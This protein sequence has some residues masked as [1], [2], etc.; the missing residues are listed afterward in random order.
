[1]LVLGCVM[2][3]CVG[4]WAS[5]EPSISAGTGLVLTPD[6]HT[7]GPA[8][9]SFGFWQ[10]A[11]TSNLFGRRFSQPLGST[12]IYGVNVGVTKHLEAGCSRIET[13]N[14]DDNTIFNAKY[15][16]DL[17]KLLSAPGAPMVAV[18]IWDFTGKINRGAYAVISKRLTLT[19]DETKTVIN[20]HLGFGRNE[21][22]GGAL[23]GPFGGI[24]FKVN[25]QAII[26]TEYDGAHFNALARWKIGHR[27]TFNG[28]AV[29]GDFTYGVS[30]N[31]AEDYKRDKDDWGGDSQ[32]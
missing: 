17:E 2:G 7:L 13:D 27:L 1:M 15:N 16:A 8:E 6:A 12:R 22:R 24:D 9:A 26:Q 5:G 28:G 10:I 32:Y 3:T 18:G 14:A 4:V 29:D 31:T 21:D 19:E 23:N 11:N 25:N 20:A 30:F